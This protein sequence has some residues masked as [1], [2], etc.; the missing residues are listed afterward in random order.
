[1]YLEKTSKDQERGPM[2]TLG[3]IPYLNGQDLQRSN[4]CKILFINF[5]W[6]ASIVEMSPF[7]SVRLLRLL[8]MIC[9]LLRRF[10]D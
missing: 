3:P 6:V 7:S 2:G 1:M 10:R 5:R 9:C 4:L 8:R